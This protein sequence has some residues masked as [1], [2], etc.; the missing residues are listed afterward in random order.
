M[1]IKVIKFS[2]LILL[3]LPA[4]LHYIAPPL[5]NALAD[6]A[7]ERGWIDAL[8]DSGDDEYERDDRNNNYAYDDYDNGSDW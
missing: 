3:V 4:L 6:V 1:F 5:V 7:E 2:V 8:I